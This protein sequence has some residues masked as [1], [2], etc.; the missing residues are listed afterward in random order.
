MNLMQTNAQCLS[1]NKKKAKTNEN[2]KIIMKSQIIV[3]DIVK[4]TSK[5]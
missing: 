2:I 4:K 3:V 1:E 5:K